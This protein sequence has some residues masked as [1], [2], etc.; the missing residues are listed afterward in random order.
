MF[1]LSLTPHFSDVSM[2]FFF[3]FFDMYFPADGEPGDSIRLLPD[4]PDPEGGET[5]HP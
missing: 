3:L 1:E 5:V 4:G 2:S